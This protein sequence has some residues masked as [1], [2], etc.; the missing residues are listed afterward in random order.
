MPKKSKKI[1]LIR[2]IILWFS[3]PLRVYVQYRF[4]LAIAKDIAIE[5]ARLRL[6]KPHWNA[7]QIRKRAR[8]KYFMELR[9]IGVA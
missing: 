3:K 8:S 6:K 5:E 2:R 4:K 9:R 1:P 7:K